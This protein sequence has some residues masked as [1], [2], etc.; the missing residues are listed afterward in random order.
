MAFKALPVRFYYDQ[1]VSTTLL[2]LSLRFTVFY[3][4]IWKRSGNAAQWNG[5]IR[6]HVPGGTPF[7]SRSPLKN[8]RQPFSIS[9]STEQTAKLENL[10]NASHS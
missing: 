2:A 5:G 8:I 9:I 6:K 7:A 1:G 3:A 10:Q 4:H